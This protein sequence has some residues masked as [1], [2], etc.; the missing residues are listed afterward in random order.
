[1]VPVLQ[2]AVL[3]QYGAPFVEPQYDVRTES[4]IRSIY[5]TSQL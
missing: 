3:P 4:C 5:Y 1:M 2:T